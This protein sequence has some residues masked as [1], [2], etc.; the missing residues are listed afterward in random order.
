[1]SELYKFQHIISKVLIALATAHV[2]VLFGLSVMLHREYVAITLTGAIFALVPWLMYA[3]RRPTEAIAMSLAVALVA[4]T[5]LLVYLFTGHGWQVEMHFYF[6]AILAMLAGFCSTRVLLTAAGFIALHHI[7]LDYLLP[8]AIYPNG[9]DIARV[10]V[11]AMIVLVE[12][13]V[14]IL[15]GRVIR[16][17]FEQAVQA[18]AIAEAAAITLEAARLDLTQSLTFKSRLAEQLGSQLDTFK[19]DVASR[20]D[21][22]NEAASALRK[23]AD[24]FAQAAQMTTAQ[25]VAASTAAEGANQKVD[26]LAR[27]GQDFLRTIADIG[28]QVSLSATMGLKAVEDAEV[29]FSTINELTLVSTEIGAVIKLIAEIS[30][31]TNLLALNATIEAAHAGEQGRG[32][33]IVATEVKALAL[34]T[35]EA[36]KAISHM[37]SHIQA[38]TAR[39]VDKVASIAASISNLNEATAVIAEAVEQRVRAASDMAGGSND[40]AVNVNQVRSS[41]QAIEIMA[42]ETARDADHLK[43]ASI[44]I[45]EQVTAIRQDVD[46][47]AAD[48][49]IENKLPLLPE[50]RS[51]AA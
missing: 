16:S 11:H 42:N 35:T 29:T 49:A 4:Q 6:F 8:S 26:S 15:I 31:R 22:L 19:A 36:A 51:A 48:L 47:F 50:A 18:Q 34:Q 27:A 39:S 33:A 7:V 1:M 41:I 20:L 14:L 32:F 46:T 45:A 25:T 10:G 21:Q 9:S 13:A 12:T 43:A 24:E 38:T 40:A 3:S 28:E 5:A 44:K 37:I 2:S 30:N 23:T 17:S